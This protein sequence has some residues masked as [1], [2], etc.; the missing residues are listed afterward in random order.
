MPATFEKLTMTTLA[1]IERAVDGLSPDE[2]RALYRYLKAQISEASGQSLPT[3]SAVPPKS[4]LDIPTVHLGPVLK[5]FTDDDGLLEEM[6][7]YR[8]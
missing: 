3:R 1:E 8:G 4:V 6:L 2:K 5:P 7:E